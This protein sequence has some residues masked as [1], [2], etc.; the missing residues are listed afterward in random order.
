M[1]SPSMEGGEGIPRLSF[2]YSVPS[3]REGVQLGVKRQGMYTAPDF[4]GR[5]CEELLTLTLPPSGAC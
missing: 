5:A 1:S 3:D 4:L 2:R